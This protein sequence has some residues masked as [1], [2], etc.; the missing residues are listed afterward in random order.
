MRGSD[1]QDVSVGFEKIF[2]KSNTGSVTAVP[3]TAGG[4]IFAS[5]RSGSIRFRLAQ[6]RS[7][8]SAPVSEQATRCVRIGPSM[9]YMSAAEIVAP[10]V[11]VKNHGCSRSDK[12]AQ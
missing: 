9:R 2:L 11:V 7:T 12:S 8:D 1:N 6:P 3:L 4:P 10:P 5:S